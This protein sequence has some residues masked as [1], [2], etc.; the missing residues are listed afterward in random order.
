MNPDIIVA[1]TLPG[2]F[3]WFAWLV[4]STIRRYKIAKLQSE[5]QTKLLDKVASG[6][7]L[8][9][10]AQTEVGRELLESLKVEQ[11]VSPY[12]RIIVAMQT[13][14]IA[15]LVGCAFLVLRSRVPEN[16]QEGFLVFGTIFAFLG[17]GFGLSA[18]ASYYLS[19]SFGLLNGTRP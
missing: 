2:M 16:A 6:Q 4:F 14:I 8:L 10:Y 3:A 11:R 5:V 7:E 17:L 9:A 19:K 18:A 12:A 1:F 13:G 15:L